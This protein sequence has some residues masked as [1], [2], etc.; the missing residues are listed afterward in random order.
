MVDGSA[1]PCGCSRADPDVRQAVG[2]TVPAWG[3]RRLL[4]GATPNQSWPSQPT[5]WPATRGRRPCGRGPGA[6]IRSAAPPSANAFGG[7]LVALGGSSLFSGRTYARAGKPSQTEPIDRPCS[8]AAYAQTGRDPGAHD[9]RA[10]ALLHHGAELR[11][12]VAGAPPT[13]APR[14]VP[15]P[16][17]PGRPVAGPARR[18]PRETNGDGGSLATFPG[19]RL[20]SPILDHRRP[21]N[22]RSWGFGEAAIQPIWAGL[23]RFGAFRGLDTPRPDCT[24]FEAAR[25]SKTRRHLRALPGAA[26]GRQAERVLPAVN[27]CSPAATRRS[28]A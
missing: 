4:S 15:S 14:A 1:V 22:R 24:Q 28:L 20:L 13:A 7:V 23:G 25:F 6:A 21:P 5:L 11:S 3:P 27:V 8:R 18:P 26:A 10:P 2:V 17:R 12:S 19:C 9:G 16:A